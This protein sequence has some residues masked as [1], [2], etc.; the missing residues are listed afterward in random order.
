MPWRSPEVRYVVYEIE[1]SVPLSF[2][3]GWSPLVSKRVCRLLLLDARAEV[4][5]PVFKCL[6]TGRRV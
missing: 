1:H 4:L 2:S 5:I 3:V 6:D